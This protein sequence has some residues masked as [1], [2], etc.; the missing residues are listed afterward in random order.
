MIGGGAWVMPETECCS[1]GAGVS[2]G[3]R[4]LWC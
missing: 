2:E 3:V 1:D 4:G